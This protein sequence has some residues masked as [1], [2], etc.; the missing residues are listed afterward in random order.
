MFGRMTIAKS[1]RSFPN[2]PE[3]KVL[4]EIINRIEPLYVA[5]FTDGLRQFKRKRIDLYALERMIQNR[6][7][8]KISTIIPFDGILDAAKLDDIYS[9]ALLETTQAS[10]EFFKRSVQRLIGVNASGFAVNQDNINVQR[11]LTNQVGT[12]IRGITT[13]SQQAVQAAINA[14]ITQGLPPRVAAR[15]IRNSIGLTP[16]QYAAVDNFQLKLLN[17][18]FAKLT[19]FQRNSILGSRRGAEFG[20]ETLLNLSDEQID[21]LTSDYAERQLRH[22][23]KMIAQNELQETLNFGQSETWEQA[24]SEGL[25]DRETTRRQWIVTPDDR[26]CDICAP[27]A[28]VIVPVKEP[29]ILPNGDLT[30]EP[31]AHIH[32]RC[33]ATLV[34]QG[35]RR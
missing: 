32:C 14:S 7:W 22:R 35:E 30:Y 12:L 8:S 24:F 2:K 27:M 21:R 20:R 16:Q 17:G 1:N 4:Q 23:A 10:Q 19:Q 6:E 31:K 33:A 28:G 29:F 15:S 9:G 11:W 25:V 26:L 13:E 3:W 5:S 34:F 18:D